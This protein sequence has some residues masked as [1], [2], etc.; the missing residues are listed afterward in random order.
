MPPSLPGYG[1][2]VVSALMTTYLLHL[3]DR[4]QTVRFPNAG[5]AYQ[6][7]DINARPGE[8]YVLGCTNDHPSTF[9]LVDVGAYRRPDFDPAA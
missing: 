9:R 8:Q 5:A 1:T 7:L 6:W 2:G 3:S 4:K